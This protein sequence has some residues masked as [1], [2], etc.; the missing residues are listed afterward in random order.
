[1][2]FSPSPPRRS[3]EELLVFFTH[4]PLSVCHAGGKISCGD[5]KT[6]L[7]ISLVKKKKL[8]GFFTHCPHSVRHAGEKRSCQDCLHIVLSLS[9]TQEEREAVG[10]F[11]TLSSFCPPIR[12]EKKLSGCFTHCPHSVRHAGAKRSCQDC[13][14]IVLI[15]SVTQEERE[16]VGTAKPIF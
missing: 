3:K 14:R 10:I 15:L 9:V 6:H 11:Y 2:L 8:W 13:L 12:S 1:M 7:L 4:C 5:C 16:A